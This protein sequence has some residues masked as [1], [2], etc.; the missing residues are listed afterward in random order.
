MVPGRFKFSLSNKM[1]NDI[2]EARHI[3]LPAS[4]TSQVLSVR[5]K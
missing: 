4:Y 5:K 3:F 1:F 2:L